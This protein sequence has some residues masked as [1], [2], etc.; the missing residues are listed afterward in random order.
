MYKDAL[1]RAK[2]L[3]SD[4]TSL[5]KIREFIFPELAESW[6]ER[7]RQFLL[8]LAK[9]CSE[10]SIDFIGEIKKGDVIAYLEKQK[11]QHPSFRFLPNDWVV[12]DGPL[13]HAILQVKDVVAGRYSFVDND[14]TLLVEDS[15]KFLRPLTPKDMEKPAE[16]SDE[17]YDII[18]NISNQVYK[19]IR[20]TLASLAVYDED[21][22][23]L[24]SK[25]ATLSYY[26]QQCAEEILKALRPS[27]KPAEEPVVIQNAA[28]FSDAAL[29]E[30]LRR[31][32]YKGKL[33]K[34]QEVE[35]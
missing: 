12:Y 6:D 14:S 2:R 15:D 16:W 30:E 10:N 18:S 5:Q 24:E 32:G 26:S 3:T 17:N 28:D 13:G 31:R 1:E 20:R 8:R 34:V 7:I 21:E 22:K 23:L 9:R 19:A 33:A 4:T 29:L 11:E 27:W 35:I 25:E